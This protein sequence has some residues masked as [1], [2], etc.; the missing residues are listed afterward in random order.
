MNIAIDARWIFPEISGIGQYTSELIRH[1]AKQ[2][3]ENRYLLIFNNADVLSG[4]METWGS[5][6]PGNF[7]AELTPYGVFSP[8]SQLRMPGR[9]R[10]WGI[11]LYHSTN[12][13][14]PFRA[15]PRSRKG[16][17][18]CVTTIH[19]VIPLIFPEHAPK[20][21][22]ARVFPIFVRIMREVG[23]RSHAIITVSRA[24]AGDIVRHLQIPEASTDRV[25]PIYNGVS[26]VFC[27]SPGG[28]GDRRRENKTILY[29]G[30]SDPYKNL[31]T[32]IRAFAKARESLS[33]PLELKIVGPKDPRYPEATGLAEDLG[34]GNAVNWTGYLSGEKLVQT[35][36]E[37]DLLV[38][39]SR[40]E[41]FGLQVIEAMACGIPVISSNAGALNEVVGDAGIVLEPD[42]VDGYVSGIRAVLSDGNL[43]RS[44]SRKGIDR[45]K[46]FSWART[47]RE[48][49]AVYK[50][51]A[52]NDGA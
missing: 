33:F 25:H 16:R 19:D 9:L 36:Q 29:V 50:S 35:Y 11:D 20:S 39:P 24:S 45:A 6:L 17:I 21:R 31:A 23:I 49:L 4:I 3:S 51:L 2:D 12:Y 7:S 47:A 27:P 42:D 52:E 30:R 46:E 14:I 22:K 48:T 15:F 43:Y 10:R 18:R 1:L 32:L 44:L 34:L 8:W 37:A 40:Y 38:H 26:D 41:G 13:M 5:E 28:P